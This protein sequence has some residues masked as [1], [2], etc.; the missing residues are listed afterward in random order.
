MPLS[1]KDR[2]TAIVLIALSQLG[3]SDTNIGRRDNKDVALEAQEAL[4][5]LLRN[6]YPHEDL[7]TGDRFGKLPLE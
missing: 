3:L 1:K 2:D 7:P 5:R 6:E 4:N